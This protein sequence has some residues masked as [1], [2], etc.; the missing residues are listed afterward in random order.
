MN[1]LR[2]VWLRFQINCLEMSIDEHEQ[3][4]HEA[5]G[6]LREMRS[7]RMTLQ[8]ELDNMQMDRP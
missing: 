1:W 2:E 7:R 4:L 3:L 6:T 5:S 8:L